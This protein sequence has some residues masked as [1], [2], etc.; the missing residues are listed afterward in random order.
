[1]INKVTLIGNLGRDPEMRRFE[2]GSAVTKFSVATNE[3]YRDRN[4]QLQTQTEWHEVVCWAGLAEKAERELKKGRLVYIEGRI[5]HRK[6]TD[7]NNTERFVTEIVANVLR[8][9][10]RNPDKPAGMGG[11][12]HDAGSGMD[13]EH[14]S[15]S[16]HDADGSDLPGEKDDLPF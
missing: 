8:T 13:S 2:N 7:Q 3:Y 10:D 1:M 4:G 6:Y 14:L 5:T 12:H 9:L 15:H 16:S 11:A